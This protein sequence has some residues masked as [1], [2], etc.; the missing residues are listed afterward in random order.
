MKN[1]SLKISLLLAFF[2]ILVAFFT[3]RS[4]YSIYNFFTYLSV[5]AMYDDPS[6]WSDSPYG[7]IED[8]EKA[9]ELLKDGLVKLVEKSLDTYS[10]KEQ[11]RFL[12]NKLHLNLSWQNHIQA[13]YLESTLTLLQQIRLFCKPVRS[14]SDIYEEWQSKTRLDSHESHKSNGSKTII[15]SNDAA[16]LRKW[17]RKLDQKYFY[18][19][20]QKKPNSYSVVRLRDDIFQSLCEPMY[21]IQIWYKAL[22]YIEYKT[23]KEAFSIYSRSSS[24]DSNIIKIDPNL[25]ELKTKARLA[26]NSEYIKF[27]NEFFHRSFFSVRNID[28]KIKEA[29]RNFLQNQNNESLN[30]YCEIML[31]KCRISGIAECRLIYDSL[32][33]LKFKGIESNPAYLY[34]L[35]E[36]AFRSR[37]Y[38]RAELLLKAIINLKKIDPLQT[39]RAEYLLNTI[40][41]SNR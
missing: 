9:K 37:N 28:W 20:M 19:A 18:T 31:S 1:L 10:I 23:E 7:F 5:G 12:H 33:K 30:E 36:T 35:G 3:Y 27:S 21:S 22:N 17:L 15:T 14:E 40:K 13:Q 39:K 8:K 24:A 29:W 11:G 6:T 38:N 25:L 16:E 41:Y 4:R 34:A 32:Y 26:K 2:F